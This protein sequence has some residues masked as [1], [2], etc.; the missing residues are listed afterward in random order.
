MSKYLKRI[1]LNIMA[2]YFKDKIYI[3][4]HSY[5]LQ[6]FRILDEDSIN[7]VQVLLQILNDFFLD[8]YNTTIFDVY[9]F[10]TF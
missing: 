2:Y 4:D 9:Q 6:A 3:L 5:Q 10:D 8:Y 1:E 7:K